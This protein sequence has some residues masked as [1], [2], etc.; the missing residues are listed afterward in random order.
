M[1]LA[2]PSA[3]VVALLGALTWRRVARWSWRGSARLVVALPRA[4]VLVPPGTLDLALCR[5]L[6]AVPLGAVVVALPG[7]LA[8]AL[9]GA[10]AVGLP[11]ALALAPLRAA[12]VA[13]PRVLALAPLAHWPWRR[14]VRRSRGAAS[15][16]GLGASRAP[17]LAP[18][19]AVIMAL[20][21]TLVVASL[22]ALVVAL[23]GA[24]CVAMPDAS[25]V[26]MFRALALDRVVPWP[27]RC[28][29]RCTVHQPTLVI[30]IRSR[31]T[32]ALATSDWRRWP[33]GISWST[34]RLGGRPC[35]ICG[36]GGAACVCACCVLVWCV[37]RRV[38]GWRLWSCVFARRR[39]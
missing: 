2:P 5:A 6:V 12:I 33:S 4:L 24:L 14:F 34:S 23:L 26:V 15:C 3:V 36:L 27:Y 38:C 11:R 21:R 22:G 17:A 10:A 39:R 20:S 31:T 9:L 25:P 32:G 7:E 19:R 16:S 30:R 1:A 35:S 28:A 37:R 29:A 8:L 13:L 18:L